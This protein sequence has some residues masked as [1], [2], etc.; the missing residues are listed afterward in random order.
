[1]K[2][3]KTVNLKKYNNRKLYAPK[4]EL[5]DQGNYVTLLDVVN[6]IKEGNEVCI[7]TREGE[8]VTN[9]VL[10]ES[11]KCL[12]LDNIDLIKIIGSFN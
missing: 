11:I 5:S 1:M 7:T 2:I 8:D 4:G 12:N 6:T 3:T 10:K 9:S